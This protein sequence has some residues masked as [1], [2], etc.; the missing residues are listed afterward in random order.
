[1]C[2]VLHFIMSEKPDFIGQ[3]LI[4]FV[5]E[6]Q[7]SPFG[8]EECKVLLCLICHVSRDGKQSLRQDEDK[9]NIYQQAVEELASLI[10]AD[11]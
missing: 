8:L 4:D 6:H 2:V 9:R 3:A 5:R 7:P 1:M 10:G 11:S